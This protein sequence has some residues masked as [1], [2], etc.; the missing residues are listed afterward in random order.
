MTPNFENHLTA[1][2][3]LVVLRLLAGSTGYQANAYIIEAA[4]GDMGHQVSGDRV[5]AD[6][7]WLA[8]QGLLST[9]S[10]AGVTIA[11]LSPRGHDVAFGKA[12]V[13]GVKRP[14]PD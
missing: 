7:A 12:I 9:T 2:R 13:P 5:A 14:Q 4:L 3:R 11:H 1:D 6:L 8:E 10:V